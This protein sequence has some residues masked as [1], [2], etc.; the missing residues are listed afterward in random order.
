MARLRKRVGG[1]PVLALGLVLACCLSLLSWL[2]NPIG[3]VAAWRGCARPTYRVDTARQEIALT[4]EAIWGAD[5][6]QEI[7]A[8]LNRYGTKATFFLGGIWLEKHADVARRVIQEGHEIGNHTGRHPHLTRLRPADIKAE[9]KG[10]EGALQKAAG[11][12][13]NLFR[14][15]YGEYNVAVLKAAEELGYRTIMW[16]ID[17]LDWKQPGVDVIVNRVIGLAH[18]GGIVLF[19]GNSPQTVEALPIVI[20]A[21]RAKGYALVT[22]SELLAAATQSE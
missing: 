18:E 8:I 3:L 16:S 20:Q 5:Y 13:T 9:I 11:T 4:F 21:L 14:P 22:V 12:K 15:P 19:H 6:I 2:G 17:S 7:L 10:F 1:L